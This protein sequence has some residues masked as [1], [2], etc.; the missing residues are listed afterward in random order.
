MT[1]TDTKKKS[2]GNSKAIVILFG[3]LLPS[4]IFK[5]ISF[6][7]FQGIWEL[8][9]SILFLYTASYI[10]S[11]QVV[12]ETFHC[13]SIINSVYKNTC[14]DLLQVLRLYVMEKSKML[15]QTSHIIKLLPQE[16]LTLIK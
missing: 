9:W 7:A 6:P 1:N 16:N 12:I 13:I 14:Y 2:Y 3:Q 10:F 11:S 8:I 15:F 5:F 4:R